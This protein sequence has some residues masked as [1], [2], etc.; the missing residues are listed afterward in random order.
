[1]L[2]GLGVVDDLC[3]HP[4]T[5]VCCRD[6]LEKDMKTRSITKLEKLKTMVLMSVT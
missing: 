2:N 4:N 3:G 1:M 6:K 5:G